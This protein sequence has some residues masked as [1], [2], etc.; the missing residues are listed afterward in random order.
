M[1]TTIKDFSKGNGTSS[2]Q[3]HLANEHMELWVSICN[4]KGIKITAATVQW[5]VEAYCTAC[6]QSPSGDSNSGAMRQKYSQEAF[7][8][9]VVE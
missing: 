7:V 6:G 8:D 3:K 1:H 5:Q 4:Q 2:M 9:A